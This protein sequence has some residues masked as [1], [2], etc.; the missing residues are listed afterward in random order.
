LLKNK[1]G[2]TL[3]EVVVA[4]ALFGIVMV[5]IFPAV[6]ML[7]LVNR[8][9]YENTEAAFVAQKTLERIIFESKDARV[10]ELVTVL[11]DNSDLSFNNDSNV[12]TP[13]HLIFTKV[14]GAYTTTVDFKAI[15]GSNLWQVLVI[16]VSDTNDI[17]G[18]RAQLETIVSLDP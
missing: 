16:V 15:S 6:M 7:N 14:E 2:L 10:N 8:V 12:L 3:I 4:I 1:K 11:T 5:T 17:E 9:S 18:R 13:E